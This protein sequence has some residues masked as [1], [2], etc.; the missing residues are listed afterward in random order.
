MNETL[1][2]R[3]LVLRKRRLLGN[4]EFAALLDTLPQAALP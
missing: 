4:D 2:L 1:P 3:T